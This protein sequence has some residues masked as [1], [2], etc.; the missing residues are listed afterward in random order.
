MH[1][2]FAFFLWLFIQIDTYSTGADFT[3]SDSTGADCSG[4]DSTG[5]DS[6]DADSTDSCVQSPSWQLAAE[7]DV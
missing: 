7:C 3:V 4:A 2:T 5:D 6:T 1:K